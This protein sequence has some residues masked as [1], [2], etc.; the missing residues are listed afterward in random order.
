[1][2][3]N[4]STSPPLS[5][6]VNSVTPPGSLV[7]PSFESPDVH[8]TGYQYN[9]TGAGVG[10]TFSSTSGIQH[11]GSAWNAAA[12]PDGVQTAFVQMTGTITQTLSLN[13]GSYTLAFRAAQRTCCGVQPVKVTVDGTQIGSLVSPASG[14]F[15]A[16]SIPFSVASSGTHTIMFAGTDPNDRTTFIDNVT[17]Q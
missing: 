14:S 4:G 16:F 9:P 15:A 1:V 2:A 6:V 7:N 13:A 12:A 17:I 3:N 8:S 11:N 10:W 5:Q